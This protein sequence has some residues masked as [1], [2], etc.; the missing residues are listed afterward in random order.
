MQKWIDE[1]YVEGT[2]VFQMSYFDFMPMG[3]KLVS[4]KIRDTPTNQPQ[5]ED[6]SR[7]PPESQG[8]EVFFSS[9]VQVTFYVD[10]GSAT[11]FP[12]N[13]EEE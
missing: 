6:W 9:Q 13:I 7:M 10:K 5:Q 8:P 1:Q 2:N 4:D 12:P 11:P 3:T